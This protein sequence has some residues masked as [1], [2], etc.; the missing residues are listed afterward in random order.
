MKNNQHHGTSTHHDPFLQK[1]SVR[2]E[3]FKF[4]KFI[5]PTIGMWAQRKHDPSLSYINCDEDFQ[6]KPRSWD[7]IFFQA[8]FEYNMIWG[9]TD[10][11]EEIRLKIEK[12]NKKYKT[13]ADK[14]R[15]EKLFEKE[16]MMIVYLR[17]EKISTKRVPTKQLN[18]E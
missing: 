1:E 9:S 10:V 17:R 4:F 7:Q 2:G 16:D 3:R 12:F 8:E 18:P 13:A 11:Q 5:S 14:K 6:D 15:R